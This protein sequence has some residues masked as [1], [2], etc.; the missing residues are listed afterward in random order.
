MHAK[1][2][3]V[4]YVDLNVS[5]VV[6]DVNAGHTVDV[7]CIVHNNGNLTANDY[8]IKYYLNGNIVSSNTGTNLLS[9]NSVTHTFHII[10]SLK[11]L[12][13]ILVVL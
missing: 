12:I 6:P 11:F 8:T 3:T 10:L 13:K 5:I 7:N 9:N 4:T 1:S 2:F